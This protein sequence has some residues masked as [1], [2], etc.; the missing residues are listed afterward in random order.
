MTTPARLTDRVWTIPNLI[1]FVRLMAIP[2]FL[3]LLLGRDDPRMAGIVLVAIGATD[4]VDGT[5]ARLLKQESELGRRLDP[6]ADRLAIVAAVVGGWI[7]GVVPG[8][9]AGPLLVREAVMTALTAWLMA[10]GFG[11]LQVRYLGKVATAGIYTSIPSFY[12]A[13]AGV[14]PSLFRPLGWT[15]GTIGLALYW[16]TAVQYGADARR[17]V[18]ASADG[19]G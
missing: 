7:A 12:L 2:Y 10:R 1:S 15:A 11:T 19:T 9:I 17:L 18:G 13:A 4:W 14:L 8:V 3:F 6:I 16:V 5:L